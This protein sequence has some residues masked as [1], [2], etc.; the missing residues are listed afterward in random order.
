MGK[1]VFAVLVIVTAFLLTT[2]WQGRSMASVEVPAGS[3]MLQ[4]RA[5]N[6]ILGFAPDR[7]CL[8]SMDHALSVQFLGTRGVM[9][10]SDTNAPASGAMTEASPLGKVLYQNLWDG[11]SL[12]YVATEAGITESTY[13]VAPGAD[14]SGIRL[15]Y[16]VPVEMRKDGSLQFKFNTGSLTESAPI[17]WQEIGGKRKPVDVAF[18][19]DEGTIGF[20]VGAYDRTQPLIIDPTYQWH[21][22]YGSG[23]YHTAKGIVTDGSGNVYV[24]GYSA[25]S[26]NGPEDQP[27]LNAFSVGGGNVNIFVIKLDSS[28]AYQWHTFYGSGNGEIALGIAKDNA[29]N[30]YVTGESPSSWTGP[31][32]ANTAALHAWSSAPGCVNLFVLKLD[33]SGAYQWH[34]FYGPPGNGGNCTG[35]IMPKGITTDN[36]G[37]VYVTGDEAGAGWTGPGGQAPVN[38]FDGNYTYNPFV[39]K[40]A[41]DGAY[42]WHTFN[43]YH[44]NGGDT[45]N[46]LAV[47]GSGSV[48]VTGTSSNNWNGPGGC[49]TPG[50]S[51]CPLNAYNATTDIFVLKLDSS[52][53]YQWHSFFG[54]GAWSGNGAFGM[55]LDN[56]GNVYVTGWSEADWNGPGQCSTPGVSPCPLNAFSDYSDIFVLKL[57]SSGAYQWHTFYGANGSNGSILARGIAINGN[58]DLY[59]SGM[60]WSTWNGPGNTPPLNPDGDFVILKLNSGGAYQWHTF[61]GLSNDYVYGIAVHGNTDVYVTGLSE[62][63]WTAPAPANTPPLHAFGAGSNYNLFVL[64]INDFVVAP[65]TVLTASVS[66]ITQTSAASG[67]NVTADGGATVSARGVCWGTSANPTISSSHT[68][69]GSGTGAFTSAITGL[70]PYTTYHVR[71]YATNSAGTGYG[72][73]IYFTTLC[74][75]Y[76]A[77]IGATPY[78]SLQGAIDDVTGSAEIRAVAGERQGALT[79]SG[80]KTINLL[81][82]YDCVCAAVTGV[83]TVHGSLTVGGG[84]AVTMADI[85]IY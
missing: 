16:N 32:P 80:N 52:G 50:V 73:D 62:S 20:Q 45:T 27:P 21:T 59:V 69:D 74:P 71:A 41:S 29:G 28:G 5:G 33:G 72:G 47:D 44:N 64:K 42:V 46:A 11:I 23:G 22:F 56:S 57:N 55:A 70:S 24:T 48:Y 36:S 12:T 35:N 39:L 78:D 54:A 9:P 7:A 65:P 43:G 38:P 10:V 18:L 82:G 58:D 49:T 6:H 14:V 26:W 68:S 63:S 76:V 15:R 37:N 66:T 85:A 4:F 79:I 83:T 53:A 60:S 8:A 2:I 84:A 3:S 17:A 77:R 75:S 34:T 1:G 31:A 13:H 19:M 81:G 61:Y 51:P 30:V 67:G 25:N 40:L